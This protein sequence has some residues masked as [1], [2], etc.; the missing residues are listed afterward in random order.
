MQ[1]SYCL[2]LRKFLFSFLLVALVGCGTQEMSDEAAQATTLSLVALS[3]E[4][5]GG[6]PPA[7]C[8][9]NVDPFAASTGSDQEVT[10]CT[11][12]WAQTLAADG[13]IALHQGCFTRYSTDI[14]ELLAAQCRTYSQTS[15]SL[16]P[17]EWLA[18]KKRILAVSPLKLHSAYCSD[19]GIECPSDVDRRTLL[20]TVNGTENIVSW[21]SGATGLGAGLQIIADALGSLGFYL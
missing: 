17:N 7:A 5:R 8:D 14:D 9:P 15:R 3:M 16:S 2:I 21:P 1:H 11:G 4:G 10:W 13:A 18:I 20:V 6:A 19:P 12:G